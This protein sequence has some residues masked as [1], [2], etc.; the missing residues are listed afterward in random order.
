MLAPF[1]ILFFIFTILPIG[2]SLVLSFTNYD[3]VSNPVFTGLNNYLRM[4]SDDVLKIVLK[5]T[6]M[7]AFITG[8]LGFML[9]FVLAWMINELPPKPRSVLS[10]LFYAPSIAG[11]VFLIWSVLFSGDSYG[12]INSILLRIGWITTPIQWLKDASYAM[13]VVII[14]QLWL[15]L[16]VSFLANLAGLQNASP[17]LY[18]AGAID[19]IRN[20]W[21]ELWYITLPSMKSILL[22]SSVMQIQSSFSA[23][24]VMSTLCGYPSVNYS[25]DTVVLYLADVGTTRFEMGYAAAISVLLFG[26]M[27]VSRI[28]IGKL[29]NMTGK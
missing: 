14:V 4:V 1:A 22:F 20:R 8:P 21:Q 16:G 26:M 28:L 6:L 23:G 9:S 13:T 3:M 7:F 5:N 27:A 11:N 18:E 12:Y 10:F 2:S 15:S 29:L 25:T 17:E 24:A 19:G